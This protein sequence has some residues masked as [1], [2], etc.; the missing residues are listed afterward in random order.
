MAPDELAVESLPPAEVMIQKVISSEQPAEMQHMSDFVAG[1]RMNS[2]PSAEEVAHLSRSID[3]PFEC[4]SC[5]VPFL[6]QARLSD[7]RICCQM[8]TTCR[9]AQWL[10][11]EIKENLQRKKGT[12]LNGGMFKVVSEALYWHIA[13]KRVRKLCCDRFAHPLSRRPSA[14]HQACPPHRHQ[15]I[16]IMCLPCFS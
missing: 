6:V 9:R 15:V 5:C 4:V 12:L 8:R 2:R 1:I 14:A 13:C 11:A 7:W 16:S 3:N 10:L